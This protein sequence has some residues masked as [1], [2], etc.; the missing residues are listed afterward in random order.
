MA[1]QENPN[2]SFDIKLNPA[3]SIKDIRCKIEINHSTD[4]N[5]AFPKSAKRREANFWR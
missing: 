3:N 4:F 2:E 1:Y 5:E